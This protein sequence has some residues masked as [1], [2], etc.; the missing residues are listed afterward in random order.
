MTGYGC[1]EAALE[2]GSVRV[3]VRSVNGKY[4]EARVHMP[5]EYAPLEP[6]ITARLRARLKRGSV[7]VRV[8]RTARG[9]G[10]VVVDLERA[11][12]YAA[13]LKTLAEHLG[14]DSDI[15]L[16]TIARAEG[17]LMPAVSA[18]EPSSVR[19]PLLEA[20]EQALD[21]VTAM[22]RREGGNLAS[23]MSRDAS[24]LAE[25]ASR[26]EGLI[27]EIMEGYRRRL[28]ERVEAAV[29]GEADGSRIVQEVALLAERSDV[30]EEI[31]RLASHVEQL[32]AMI[33]EEEGPVGRRLDFLAQEMYREANTLA[34]KGADA[35]MVHTAVQMK[36]IV[37][38]LREQ[39][40]NVL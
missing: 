7:T 15:D 38:R 13:A 36:V 28:L 40:Q 35:A 17:V 16:K 4:L 1:A 9:E 5:K 3:E 23:S 24:D 26:L 22:R 20:L 6:E 39:A 18:D 37:E 25:A 21:Q 29:G 11:S 2:S 12:A 34:S 31:D 19:K 27:P 32:K 10:S 33:D 8:E 14:L 30:S